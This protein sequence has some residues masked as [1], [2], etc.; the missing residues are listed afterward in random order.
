MY[1]F[2][3]ERESE[4]ETGE[5]G[6]FSS[7]VLIST[8]N[9]LSLRLLAFNHP[10]VSS[11]E[12]SSIPIAPSP[13]SSGRCQGLPA[14]LLLPLVPPQ[15][16]LHRA[17]RLIQQLPTFLCLS[18]RVPITLRIKSLFPF[19]LDFMV[20]FLVFPLFPLFPPPG[21]LFPQNCAGS[22][23]TISDK[24]SLAALSQ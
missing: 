3:Y 23:T 20:F 4:G 10:V 16:T 24:P 11:E 21:M 2:I 17:A 9:I 18:S 22:L 7:E 8:H 5:R 14:G 1:L 13:S 19:F 6:R 15:L 12:S